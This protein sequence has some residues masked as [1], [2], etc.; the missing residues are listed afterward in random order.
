M[1]KPWALIRGNSVIG[2]ILRSQLS[3]C[4]TR[5]FAKTIFSATQSCSIVATLFRTIT[6]L[7]QRFQVLKMFQFEKVDSFHSKIVVS[8]LKQKKTIDT[9]C[10]L[11]FSKFQPTR[12]WVNKVNLSDCFQPKNFFKFLIA[13]LARA[14]PT[15]FPGF[16]LLLRERTLVAAGHMTPRIWEPKIRV[17]KNS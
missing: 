15:L 8:H 14:Q 11:R 10:L 4:Y 3:C 17:G 16:S 13:W 1:A 6:T 12:K 2:K 7:F 5:R 9:G